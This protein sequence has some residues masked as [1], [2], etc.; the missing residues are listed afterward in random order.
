PGLTQE[1]EDLNNQTTAE[2]ATENDRITPTEAVGAN[3]SNNEDE[4]D[5]TADDGSLLPQNTISSVYTIK[6]ELAEQA[7]VSIKTQNG[8]KIVHDL[9]GPGLREYHSDQ[10]MHFRIGN[11]ETLQ[12]LIND[13]QVEL[14]ELSEEDIADFNWPLNPSS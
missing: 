13:N 7:W 5:D 9:I 11:V 14:S 4:L 12:L 10:P 3:D 2:E 6:M 1:S 8:E